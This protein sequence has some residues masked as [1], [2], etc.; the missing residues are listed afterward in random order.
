MNKIIHSAKALG[1][2][3][4]LFLANASSALAADGTDETQLT[5]PLGG[6]VLPGGNLY[7]SDI[8]SSAIFSKIIPF[9]IKYLVGLAAALAVIALMIGGYQYLTAYG[10]TSKHQKATKTLTWAIIGLVL[11]IM[12]YGIVTLITSLGFGT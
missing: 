1:L 8:K 6:E 11:S 12:A 5:K 2:T 4:I 9:V 7:Q 10:D 3:A